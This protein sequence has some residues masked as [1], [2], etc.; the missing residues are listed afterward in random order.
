MLSTT[1]P[2]NRWLRFGAVSRNEIGVAGRL[3]A[4]FPQHPLKL[5]IKVG[6]GFLATHR[7]FPSSKANG[8]RGEC[9]VAVWTPIPKPGES[10]DFAQTHSHTHPTQVVRVH[11]G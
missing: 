7:P 11:Q 2:N 6:F 8:T 3:H 1:W 9:G 5:W 10:D 4:A